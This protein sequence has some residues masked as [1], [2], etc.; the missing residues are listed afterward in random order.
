MALPLRVLFVEDSQDD[1]MLLLF[2]LKKGGYAPTFERVETREAM[3]AALDRGEWDLILADYDLPDFNGIDAL[4][5]VKEKGLDLPF[6]IVSG[7]IG[8]ATAVETMKAGA[9]DYIFKN[10]LARLVP[11]VKRELGD[12]RVRHERKQAE[13]GLRQSEQLIHSTLDSL[14]SNIAILNEAGI[15][16]YTNRAW[17]TF[18][19]QNH[20]NGD[21]SMIGV[22][23]LTLC[24][25]AA[26]SATN[27]AKTARKAARGIREVFAGHRKEFFLEY[28]CH[29]PQEQRWFTMRAN[30]FI[31]KKPI[32]VVVSH[33]NITELK[34]IEDALRENEEKFRSI[35]EKSGIG[36]ALADLEGKPLQVNPAICK[37]LGYSEEEF[38][39]HSFTELT[40]PDDRET[41][42]SKA[43]SLIQGKISSVTMEKRYIHADKHIVWTLI[44]LSMIRDAQGKPLFVAGQAQDITE[45]KQAQEQLQ[46]KQAELAHALRLTTMNEM[47]TTLA[48]ELNQPLCSILSFAQT[49]M[50]VLKNGSLP[51]EELLPALQEISAQADLAGKIIQHVRHYSRKSQPKRFPLDLNQVIRNSIHFIEPKLKPK[52][53]KLEL[54]LSDPLP[55]LQADEI[56]IE[57]VLLNLIQNAMDATESIENPQVEIN[58]TTLEENQ[59]RV[60]VKDNGIGVHDPDRICEPFLTT[61]PHGLGLGLPISRSIIENHGGRLWGEVNPDGG[62]TFYFTLPLRINKK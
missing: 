26:A 46:K 22:N 37:M 25:T 6:I 61:K 28:P 33:E 53:I 27:D 20:Y 41:E 7:R 45:R 36:M 1:A 32:W 5:L 9:H 24:D 44:T 49:C 18:A 16:E 58:S 11:A 10:N 59:V 54:H 35:F 31:G 8:E 19:R 23:Y 60:F 38:L 51:K 13:E 43:Q 14:A 47:A 48:H 17:R 12:A 52:K 2:E 34:R 3:N 42:Y 56:Q 40:H 30:P 57:Q 4:K 62:M 55:L 29:S 50:D 21:P 39:K 15:I